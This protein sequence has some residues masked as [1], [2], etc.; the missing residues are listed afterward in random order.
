MWGARMEPSVLKAFEDVW[1]TNELIVRYVT[2]GDSQLKTRAAL[3]ELTIPQ[4]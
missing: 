4:L 3:R 2:C 1:G